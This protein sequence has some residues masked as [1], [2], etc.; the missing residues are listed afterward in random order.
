MSKYM[1]LPTYQ[2]GLNKALLAMT[3][4]VV[5]ETQHP[6]LVAEQAA[7]VVLNKIKMPDGVA[8]HAQSE[9]GGVLITCIHV[10]GDALRDSV[11]AWTYVPQ[12]GG[13]F[14]RPLFD[15]LMESIHIICD[16]SQQLLHG[17]KK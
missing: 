10:N 5:A 7:A 12:V 9:G 8:L 1:T 15:T 14:A 16:M 2:D 6:T 13:H 3:L 4:D 11:S 17:V